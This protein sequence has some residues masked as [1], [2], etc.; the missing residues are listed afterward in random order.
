[1]GKARFVLDDNQV[2]HERGVFRLIPQDELVPFLTHPA[3]AS[4]FFRDWCLPFFQENSLDDC[5]KMILDLS[6][7]HEDL[8]NDTNWLA[9]RLSGWNGPPPGADID[10]QTENDELITIVHRKMPMKTFIKE[11]L[12]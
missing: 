8:V 6:N 5:L 1:M 4:C 2:D 3:A 7:V 10:L 9:S 11:Y 12:I